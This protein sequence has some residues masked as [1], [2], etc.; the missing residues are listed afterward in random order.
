MAQVKTKPDLSKKEASPSLSWKENPA[1]K[2]L[3]DTLVSILSKE[4]IQTA[5][6]NPE[7]FSK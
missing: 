2:K 1:A 3:L 7:I 6:E 4:Y 5:K